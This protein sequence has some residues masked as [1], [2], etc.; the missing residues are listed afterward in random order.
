[1]IVTVR[2]PD[3]GRVIDTDA[4]H[5]AMDLPAHWPD[6]VEVVVTCDDLEW[7]RPDGENVAYHSTTRRLAHY[8]PGERCLVPTKR[9]SADGRTICR[10]LAKVLKP[11]AAL[12]REVSR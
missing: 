11:G 12:R 1:M 10:D 5:V 3:T 9:V 2:E 6:N 4:E 8:F 7:R